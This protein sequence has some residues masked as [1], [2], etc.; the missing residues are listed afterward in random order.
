M[1]W[2]TIKFYINLVSR[3]R[4]LCNYHRH[5]MIYDTLR[6]DVEM[7]FWFPN[8]RYSIPINKLQIRDAAACVVSC[9]SNCVYSTVTVSPDTVVSGI[10]LVF[11]A[12]ERKIQV[13]RCVY[14]RYMRWCAQYARETDVTTI[15]AMVLQFCT[16][17][18]RRCWIAYMA[19]PRWCTSWVSRADD[20]RTTRSPRWWHSE[21]LHGS[22]A[23]KGRVWDV[24]DTLI[25]VKVRRISC[26]RGWWSVSD[27]VMGCNS[28]S[29]FL[30]TTTLLAVGLL[31]IALFVEI[32]CAT[33]KSL[34]L[35]DCYRT[36]LWKLL[37]DSIVSDVVGWVSQTLVRKLPALEVVIF[38]FFW[39]ESIWGLESLLVVDMKVMWDKFKNEINLYYIFPHDSLY[40][41]L[42]NGAMLKI[43]LC[44][45]SLLISNWLIWR[46]II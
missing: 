13:T 16:S 12:R 30:L 35:W 38:F 33:R 25:V 45:F 5:R 1:Q 9:W 43:C 46:G 37:Y 18:H 39:S 23:G 11:F 41:Y 21:I 36:R 34:T 15:P 22:W 27:A 7:W 40:A 2:F 26:E 6:R 28:R 17:M 14:V 3:A 44:K 4:V 24:T 42:N 8:G 32:S 10:E 31:S 19:R 20:S 29:S